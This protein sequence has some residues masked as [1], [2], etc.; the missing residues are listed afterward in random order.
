MSSSRLW[1]DVL[2][3]G[4]TS[5]GSAPSADLVGA[6]LLVRDVTY[7]PTRVNDSG[8]TVNTSYAG[9]IVSPSPALLRDAVSRLRPGVGVSGTWGLRVVLIPE[10]ADSLML[11][12]GLPGYAVSAD[13]ARGGLWGAP[14]KIVVLGDYSMALETEIGVHWPGV[15]VAFT[16]A[17][18][19]AADIRGEVRTLFPSV[20]VFVP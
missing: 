3:I 1:R 13:A 7:Q 11:V 17:D 5:Q 4:D 12:A 9:G 6:V 16:G 8:Q 18:P 10:A 15:D 20:A 19:S 2:I 14:E